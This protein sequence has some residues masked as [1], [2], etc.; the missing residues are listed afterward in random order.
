LVDSSLWKVND[1]AL[2][3]KT[4]VQQFSIKKTSQTEEKR[5]WHRPFILFP[6]L[7]T[8]TEKISGIIPTVEVLIRVVPM[9]VVNFFC[10][11]LRIANFGFR[12]AA[13]ALSLLSFAAQAERVIPKAVETFREPL[14][15]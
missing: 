15:P 11:K 12:R 4:S 8:N 1:V 3:V 6:S 2:V 10:G 5:R 9:A 14:A 13:Y 7:S